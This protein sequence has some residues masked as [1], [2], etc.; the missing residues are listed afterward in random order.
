MAVL[1]VR[2]STSPERVAFTFLRD[3][4]VESGSLT[5][6]ELHRRALAVAAR[7]ASLGARG[8]R[9]ILIYPQGLEFIVAFFGCLYAGVIAVPASLPSRKQGLE[10]LQR[11]AADS[12][13]MWILSTGAPLTQ[14]RQDAGA[15][16]A[17]TTLTW[18]DTE[19]S[20]DTF[21]HSAQVPVDDDE[22]A[23]LQYTS[24]STGWPRGV[25][26]THAN[27]VANQR[28]IETC[29]GRAEVTVYVSWLP[30]FHDMGLGTVL[31]SV[32]LGCHCVLMSPQAFLQNPA[33]WLRAISNYRG[34]NSG[35]PDFAY[36]L[37]ARRIRIDE[38]KTLDL[39]S[40]RLAF[41]GSEPVRATT[42]ERFADAFRECGF[43]PE[44]AR[45][46][47]GLAEA[48]LLVSGG[49]PG[50]PPFVQSFSAS[51]LRLGRGEPAAAGVPERTLVSC[52]YA[53]LD[54]ELIIVN[55]DTRKQLGP[56]Q[57]GEIWTRGPS[58]AKGYWGKV[59][60]TEATFRMSTAEGNGPFLRTG[61]L[62]FLHEGRLF[63]TGRHK[64]LIIIRGR[65]HYPQDIEASVSACHPTL[66]SF[67]C[68]A[69]S[70]EG[71]EGEL[72]V[73]V[74]EVARTA[75]RTLDAAEVIRAIR[76]VVSEDHA[77]QTHAVVLVKPSTLPRTTSGKMRHG[78]CRQA[79]LDQSLPA[80]ASWVAPT[81]HTPDTDA[82]PDSQRREGSA[83]ADRLIEWL[84]RHAAD[85]ISSYA[86]DGR[87]TVPAALLRDFAKQGLLGMQV[88]PQYGGLGLGQSDTARVVEQLAAFDFALALFV[89]LNNHLGIQP[90]AK[91]AAAPI[92][93]LLLPGLVH[94]EDLA[95]FA[96]QEPG[97]AN[98]SSS[99]AARA[100]VDSEEHWQLFGT[101]YLDGVQKGASIII[102][103]ARH[104]EPP[105][106]SAFVVSEPIDGLRQLPEGLA[107]GVLGFTRETIVLDGVGVGRDNLLGGLGS[108]LD[109]A[110]EA[111]AHARLAIA[112]ACVG[113]MKRCAQL[114]GR[115][116]LYFDKAVDS[117]LTP[118]PVTLSRLGSVTARIDALECLVHRTAR[119]ID[120]GHAVPSEAFAACRILGPDLLLRSI[121]DLTQVGARGNVAETDRIM[122]LYRDAGL[123]RHFDGPPEAIAEHTGAAVM[124]SDASLRLLVEEV[125]C[126]PDAVQW[127]NPVL[128][129]VR[130]RM[131]TLSGPLARRAQRWGHTRAG[132][133]TTWLVLL[134]AVEGT[135]RVAPGAELAR[136]RDW[137]RAQLE[138]ALSSVRFGTPSETATLDSSDIAAT[139]A[140]YSRTIGDLD[141]DRTSHQGADGSRPWE[142]MR[143]H[144]GAQGGV[145]TEEAAEGVES[146]RRELRSW[147]TSW[148]ARRL[149]IPVSKVEAGR[150]FADHGLD[151]V[152]S[153]ELAKALSDKIGREL[154][155][156]LLWNFATIEALVSHL[157]GP[158]GMAEADPSQPSEGAP[159]FRSP[160][161]EVESQLDDEIARLEEK[162]GSRS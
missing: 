145:S 51:R 131:T 60:E 162:L 93:A 46:V 118:N 141:P 151:S 137:A 105:G 152:A 74:Q 20:L 83:R 130:R 61:D 36:E 9:A 136:A 78:V 92:K 38:R 121:D 45:P 13:A 156:T 62:G 113:G 6:G 16:A 140:A 119:A 55:P 31:Q 63:V 71:A 53:S 68:A 148:L 10:I 64:D 81:R 42:V 85:L 108:G 70:I 133:L 72:L 41:N 155:E 12:G 82:D 112:A 77:L 90:V 89:G 127:I 154:D 54:T 84:R 88:E 86:S 103:F 107:I 80:I 57:V 159:T 144:Q 59:A 147:I 40:W 73:V 94:G 132:E 33:R 48:T 28:Q 128:G 24:G 15:T 106:I 14:L 146:S 153:V 114:V 143:P 101:K 99:M 138:Q 95:A 139:F 32:W 30:M 25:A 109:I 39:A 75:L 122:C 142:P 66:V 65:N 97:G 1:D 11:V 91:Y 117:R 17:L 124:E 34:T 18:F 49:H 157:V 37:C 21:A 4:E 134:A 79:F 23:L 19:A 135:L 160:T 47:Y 76:R 22:I 96:F 52:G 3:G 50:E 125:L 58:V 111:M 44:A 43:R 69:F 2:A 102:V 161:Q 5:F 120:A 150:S 26:V 67:G 123:L 27:L 98:P 149:Q 115:D 100:I 104:E 8:E 56:G 110:S 116:G 29:F 129:T 126:A 7:L 35:G 158:T 87:R